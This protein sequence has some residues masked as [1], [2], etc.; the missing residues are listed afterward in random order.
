MHEE[1]KIDEDLALPGDLVSSIFVL[2]LWGKKHT[3]LVEVL[4]RE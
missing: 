3:S 1:R 2:I 4:C